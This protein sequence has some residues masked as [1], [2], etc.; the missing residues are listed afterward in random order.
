MRSFFLNLN[1][2]IQN[3]R[4]VADTLSKLKN[5]TW[6]VLNEIKSQKIELIFRDNNELWEAIEGRIQ[7]GGHYEIAHDD[8][9]RLNIS[10]GDFLLK[11]YYI[12]SEMV[13]FKHSGDAEY[14][15]LVNETKYGRELNTI[16]DIQDYFNRKLLLRGGGPTYYYGTLNRE[17]GPYSAIQLKNLVHNKNLNKNYFVKTSTGEHPRRFR[18]GVRIKDIIRQI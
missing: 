4:R 3:D 18:D 15:V 13:V 5:Q 2:R 17:F 12:S 7:S 14:S 1:L 10:T 8:R 9:L 16:A 6:V 11:I